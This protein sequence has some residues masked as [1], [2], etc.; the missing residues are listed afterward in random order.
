M[1]GV[2]VIKIII[3]ALITVP[4]AFLRNVCVCACCV[5]VPVE[6]AVVILGRSH[7][8]PFSHATL[9]VD[10]QEPM[11]VIY[12]MLEFKFLLWLQEFSA[13]FRI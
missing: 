3:L 2:A 7:G 5:V 12:E 11:S 9:A 13:K 10:L 1:P 4:V 8:L 6:L